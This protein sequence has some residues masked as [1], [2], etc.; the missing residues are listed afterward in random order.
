MNI[1]HFKEGM[2]FVK[3]WEGGYVNHPSDPGEATNYGISQRSHPE[4]DIENLTYQQA[5]EIY[6]GEYW[7]K[8]GCS[9]LDY[10]Y[11][12]AVFDTAVNCGVGRATHWIRKAEDVMDYLDIRREY[13][14]E[15]SK[16][17]RFKPFLRGWLNRWGDL[18][19]LVEIGM[20]RNASQ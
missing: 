18:R 3:K 5:A 1:N 15:L 10:P 14:L 13:Y 20:L 17:K 11:N 19:K 6:Y 12:I 4:V 2:D 9:E 7:G 8:A 16:Q